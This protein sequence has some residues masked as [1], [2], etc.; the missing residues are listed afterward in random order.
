MRDLVRA[1]SGLE[2]QLEETYGV[3]L[4]EAMVLCSVGE[5]T[6]SAGNIISCTGMTASHASKTIRSAEDKGL[7]SRKLGEHD[8]RQ[9]YFVLT[10]KGKN[11]LQHI[12]EQGIDVPEWLAA[13][14]AVQK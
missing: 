5:D 1:L 2:S 10:R 7:L 9:M 14:F 11:R 6:V 4:N 8:K 12:K 13:L 3:T